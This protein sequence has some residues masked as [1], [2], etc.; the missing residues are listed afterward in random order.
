MDAMDDLP[1]L[2]PSTPFGND[3]ARSKCAIDSSPAVVFDSDTLRRLS[4]PQS[5]LNGEAIS[6]CAALLL[7]MYG[8][9]DAAVLSSYELAR[10]LDDTPHENLWRHAKRSQFWRKPIWIIPI[11]RKDEV[12]WT[13]ASVHRTQARISVFDSL[14]G[15]DSTVQDLQVLPLIF[16]WSY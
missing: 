12:H 6:G 5:F 15:K 1:P 3:V 7:T 2:P 16:H 8:D 9:T 13:V 4:N 14:A 10:M 11:H